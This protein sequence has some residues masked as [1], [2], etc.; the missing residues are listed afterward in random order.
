M[1]VY[2]FEQAAHYSPG[3]RLPV[4]LIVIHTVEAAELPTTSKNAADYYAGSTAPHASM[5]ACVGGPVVITG[6]T[7]ETVHWQDT[8]YAAPPANDYDLAGQVAGAGGFHVEHVGYAAQTAAQWADAFST[9]ELENSARYV[10]QKITE[11][12]AGQP[13][14][15]PI[16]AVRLSVS[17]VA[18]ALSGDRSITGI[19]GH[20]DINSAMTYLRKNPE[21]SHWDPGTA[22]PWA[23][24]VARVAA[25]LAPVAPPAPPVVV[26]PN[27]QEDDMFLFQ[28]SDKGM[29]G[30]L[31][32]VHGNVSGVPT[33]AEYVALRA[34]GLKAYTLTQAQVTR[35]GL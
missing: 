7:I 35:L 31:R 11:I 29:V 26:D 4:Q 30:Y 22:F 12:N 19:C 13:G 25:L 10:A 27:V 20:V 8:A 15:T 32:D 16:R 24:Y 18:A 3:R 14:H 5:H 6:E 34:A 23:S 33:A 28:I 1:A 9:G 21:S 2:A 17:Q